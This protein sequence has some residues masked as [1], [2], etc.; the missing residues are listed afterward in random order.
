MSLEL[1]SMSV[2]DLLG[3][4]RFLLPLDAVSVA[5]DAT[6]GLSVDCGV[7]VQMLNQLLAHSSH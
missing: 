3:G 5:V 6:N 1:T 2:F 7:I 4:D